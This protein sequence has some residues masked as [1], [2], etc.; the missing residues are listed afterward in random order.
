MIIA[1]TYD[2]KHC[3]KIFF[4]IIIY[5]YSLY[6]CVNIYSLSWVIIPFWP[7]KQ[8][9]IN[10]QSLFLARL[11]NIGRIF[12]S[13]MTRMIVQKLKK[14]DGCVESDLVMF[15]EWL[16]PSWH[17]SATLDICRT[18]LATPGLLNRLFISMFITMLP[19]NCCQN[20]AK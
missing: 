2:L 19:S 8:N 17:L 12:M 10:I 20:M 18:S 16:L 13:D 14:Q 15:F 1:L 4:F 6:F 11:K 9:F 3:T 7:N 5:F